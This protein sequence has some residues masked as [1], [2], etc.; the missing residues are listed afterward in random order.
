MSN[1]SIFYADDDEDDIMFF[2]DAVD[3]V[4]TSHTNIIELHIHKN[5]ENLV[6]GIMNNKFK[7]GVVF[8]DVN[9]PKKSGLE[10]LKEIRNE[11]T[12][13]QVPVVM[14]STSSSKVDI[15]MS[16][17]FGAN[18]YAI[19]PYDF[20]DLIKMISDVSKINW[21]S[22]KPDLNNFILVK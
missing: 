15:E 6:E 12:I 5:G 18:Y 14:Y 17:N 21:M 20:N 19:K 4:A 22:H 1:L 13:Y 7:N 9:M 11:P 16:L 2:N 3:S 10:L 8:L